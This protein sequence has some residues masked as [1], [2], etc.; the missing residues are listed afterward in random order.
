MSAPSENTEFPLREMSSFA[1]GK[2]FETECSGGGDPPSRPPS[3]RVLLVD[4]EK[5][6]IGAL[7]RLL[8]RE[9]YELLSA[10][11]GP[12]AIRLLEN[13][14]VH[15]IISDHRMPGMSGIELLHEVSVR[16]PDT[17]RIILSGYSDVNTIIA[18]VNE[19]EIYKFLVKPWNDEEIK[20]HVQRALEQF[21][22]REENRRM[23]RR[24]EEQNRHLR[25]LNVLLEQAARD[26]SSGL[27]STQVLLEEIGV[28][29]VLLDA[30]GL[31]I[32]ANRHA[33]EIVS[34]ETP[35]LVGLPAD[36][37]LPPLIGELTRR[38]ADAAGNAAARFDL[39]GRRLQC[40]VSMVEADEDRR[41]SVIAL[42]EDVS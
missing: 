13:N 7:R 11:S 36:M 15:L 23:A 2:P 30:S 37:A 14:P 33:N 27:A 34:A 38:A 42:W 19:G 22:L 12:E 8:R 35:E 21:D 1:I 20:L 17:V 28:G 5:R 16:W 39:E 18:A 3:H 41:G 32:A 31:I 25:D 40:R 10:N 9:S 6:V 26:A 24:I 29:V 4:D